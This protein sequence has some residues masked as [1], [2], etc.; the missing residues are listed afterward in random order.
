MLFP[1]PVRRIRVF[2]KHILNP[3]ARR[4]ARASFG[5]V[6]NV[7]HVGRRSGKTYETPIFV[8]PA[9]DGFVIALTYGPEV[10]WYKNVLAAGACS[11]LWHGREYP[12]SRVEPMDSEAGRA[13][14]PFPYNPIL[15][16]VGV[17]DFVKM[18]ASQPASAAPA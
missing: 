16:F 9:P 10:D 8:R 17:K 4:L 5:P 6:A 15:R 3:V 1:E 14:W 2:N 18:T 7:R 11:V 12:I 13:A